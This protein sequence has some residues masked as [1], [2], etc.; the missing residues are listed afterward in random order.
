MEYEC[1][2]TCDSL[3]VEDGCLVCNEK[4]SGYYGC[5]VKEDYGCEKY[6]EENE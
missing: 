6:T 2:K 5:S 3:V 1:C 4:E